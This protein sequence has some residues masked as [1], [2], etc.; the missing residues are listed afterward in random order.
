MSVSPEIPAVTEDAPATPAVDTIDAALDSVRAEILRRATEDADRMLEA[1]RAQAAAARARAESE[2][3]EVISHAEA[4]GKARAAA[5]SAVERRRTTRERRSRLLA[6]QR[7]AYD[8]WRAAAT[9]A[10]LALR[11]HPD[12]ATIRNGLRDA[13]IRLLG[14]QCDI[15]EDPAGGL[16][17]RSGGRVLD[18][19][20][21]TIAAR[22]LDRVEPEIGGLWA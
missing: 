18:L 7:D 16:V 4:A 17:A 10:V 1:A 11:A 3:S 15:V 12:Y 20:L 8:R 19:R 2:A 14:P 21:S 13:A 6:R 22:A 5:V 9:A